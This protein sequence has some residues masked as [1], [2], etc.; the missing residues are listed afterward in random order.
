MP[1][2][3][4]TRLYSVRLGAW[5]YVGFLAGVV[6][7]VSGFFGAGTVTLIVGGSLVVG[8][9]IVFRVNMTMTVVHTPAWEMPAW[10]VATA[11]GYLGLTVSMGWILAFN[12]L[13]P[14]LPV[15]S[16]LPVHLALGGVGWFTLTLMGVS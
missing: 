15:G 11:L 5:H 8:A 10:Y 16:A 6:L 14:F 1:V 4:N 7:L 3:L 12:F 9:V 2:L 13:H